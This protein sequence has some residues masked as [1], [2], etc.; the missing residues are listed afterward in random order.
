MPNRPFVHLHCHTHYSLLDGASRIPELVEQAKALGMNA[1]AITDHGNLYGAIEFYRE[2]KEAGINPIIGYEAY[3]APGRRTERTT[4]GGVGRRAR[5]P[6]DAAGQERRRASRTSSSS[7]RSRS[8]RA[9]TTCRGSTRSS[10]KR[11]AEGLICLSGCARPSSATSSCKARRTRPSELADWF[12][13]VFGE[14]T[15]TSRS[16]TTAS[17]SSSDCAEG[18]HRHRQPARPAARGH[19]RRPLPAP[20]RRRGPRRPVLHQHRQDARR[21][22]PDEVRA[23]DQFYVRSPEEMY[24]ALPGPRRGRGQRGQEIAERVDIA[25]R[26][27]EAALPRLHAARR[28]RRPRTTCASCASRACSERYGEQPAAGRPRPARTR[29]GHH[30]PDG[31]RQYFLIVWDFVRFA[32]EN[33]IPSSARGSAC[34][35]LVSYVLYLSH[36]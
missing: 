4:G 31:L 29:A 10:S 23:R 33:G 11:H 14:R 9:S 19:Q 32:R 25:A 18:R 27:Q 15:S 21:P 22:E 26:L 13:K 3:V 6:P 30:L 28:A 2:G 12:S 34:G 17:T 7:R 36:V 5:L 24:D 20:G 16:R 35:A 8:S 1:L